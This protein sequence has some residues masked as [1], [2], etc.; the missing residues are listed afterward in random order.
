MHTPGT[1]ITRDYRQY[2]AIALLHTLQFTVTHAQGVSVFTSCILA[3]DLSQS[4]CDFISHM[5]S[6]W[7]SLIPFLPLFCSCQFRRLD[8]VQILWSEA[9]PAMLASRNSTLRFST[10]LLFS[11]R[12]RLLTVS[13]YNPSARAPQ[14]TAYI[15]NEMCLPRRYLVVDVLLSLALASAG[16]CLSSRCLAVGL[17]V[18]AFFPLV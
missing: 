3:T 2:S 4:H 16:I 10:R 11:T 17:H 5:K 18:T 12:S 1:F 9:H 6:S 13:F 15:V 14:K 7:H 8:S